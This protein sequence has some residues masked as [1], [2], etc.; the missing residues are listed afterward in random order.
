[1]LNVQPSPDGGYPLFL[2]PSFK[3]NSRRW[4]KV[5][6][7][8]DPGNDACSGEEDRPAQEDSLAFDLYISIQLFSSGGNGI[9][10]CKPRPFISLTEPGP[11]PN[12]RLKMMNKRPCF[13]LLSG[14]PEFKRAKT[15]GGTFPLLHLLSSSVSP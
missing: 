3:K 11:K 7:R 5:G 15:E 12:K 13:V 8:L 4:H 1:M 9:Q 6:A 10:L 2:K 14:I